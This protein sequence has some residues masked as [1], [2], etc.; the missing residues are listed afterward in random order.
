MRVLV[1][2]AGV[3]GSIYG[4]ALAESGHHVVHF[5]R[6]RRAA[7]L[8]GGLALDVYDRR[9]GHKRFFRGRYRLEAIEA[10][11]PTDAFEL[12]IVPVKHYALFETLK[13]IVPRAGAADFLLLTQNWQGSAEIDR[14]LPRGRYLFGDAKA[15]GTFSEGTLVAALYAIDLGPPEGEPEALARKAAA[16]FVSAGI[17]TRLQSEMLQYLWIQYAIT[18]GPWAALVQAG[19]LDAFL[20][21]REAIVRAFEAGRECLDVVARRGVALASY[22]EARPFLTKSALLR[23]F[24]VW[25]MRRMFRHNEYTKRCSAH[26]FGDPIEV[27]TFYKDLISTGRALGVSMP[28]MESFTEAMECTVT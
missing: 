24:Y 15:G 7:T 12:V 28:V 18:G 6:P 26:A 8:R 23:E 16:L 4:W 2:G 21:E 11:S 13:E 5:V 27:Q 20:K 22:A 9:K 10:L 3:I 17:R 14:I 1:I 19:S 25:M